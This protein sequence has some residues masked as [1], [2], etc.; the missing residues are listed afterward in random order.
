MESILH[1]LRYPER[2]QKSLALIFK[3]RNNQHQELVQWVPLW[4]RSRWVE[5]VKMA[6]T[7]SHNEWFPLVRFHLTLLSDTLQTQNYASIGRTG[8]H[9]NCYLRCNVGQWEV[10]VY[11][12][13]P[14]PFWCFC[15]KLHCNLTGGHYVPV[16]KPWHKQQLEIRNFWQPFCWIN[17]C[18]Y[19]WVICPKGPNLYKHHHH[20]SETIVRL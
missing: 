1:L 3:E 2:W 13:A 18:G 16:Y 6:T 11:I 9:S 8:L 10:L 5:N 12:P 15:W 7:G 19:F 20:T 17:V 4:M 14:P